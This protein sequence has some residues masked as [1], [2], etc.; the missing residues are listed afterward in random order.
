MYDYISDAYSKI[1]LVL[2]SDYKIYSDHKDRLRIDWDTG[3]LRIK[4]TGDGYFTVDFNNFADDKDWTTVWVGMYISKLADKVKKFI[5]KEN[6]VET[7]RDYLTEAYI[8]LRRELSVDKYTMSPS[9]NNNRDSIFIYWND[10]GDYYAI[11]IEHVFDGNFDIK[12]LRKY[13]WETVRNKTSLAKLTDVIK[14]YIESI[15]NLQYSTANRAYLAEA[16]SRLRQKLGDIYKIEERDVLDDITIEWD[17]EALQ[18]VHTGNGVFD[19]NEKEDHY[20]VEV[21][22]DIELDDLAEVVAEYIE[23]MEEIKKGFQEV[24]DDLPRN[25]NSYSR[26]VHEANQ[27]WWV[28]A[29]GNKIERNK[30][31]LLMLITSEIA[32]AMEG[33][34][35]GLMDDKLPNREMAEVELADALIRIFDYAGAFGYDLEGAYQEKM[36]YNKTRADHSYEARSKE[37]GKKW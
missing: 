7:K 31:E 12:C 22:F 2:N 18:I 27:K 21:D 28:D 20:W 19:I 6:S 37:G 13:V 30:G 35:K 29:N 33:E 3:S 16:A 15:N 11:S 34:R 25:L 5:E 36:A 26:E 4:H 17:D 14:T 32:E 8:Q 10:S 23:H 1:R 24:L 9:N